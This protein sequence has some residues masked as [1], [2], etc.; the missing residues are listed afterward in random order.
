MLNGIRWLVVVLGL[1]LMMAAPLFGADKVTLKNGEVLEGEIVEQTDSYVVLRMDIG[2]IERRVIK[3][4]GEVAS[5][6]RESEGSEPGGDGEG[7]ESAGDD[8]EGS[9][10]GVRRPGS[11]EMAAA[12]PDGATR[13]AFIRLGNRLEGKDM[14][15]PY[16]NGNALMRSTE[17]LREMPEELRPEVVVLEIDSG[18]GAVAELEDIIEAIEEDL[19][20]DFRVVA[21][22]RFAISGAAFTAMNMEEI[23]FMSSGQMGGNVAFSQTGQGRAQSVQGEGLQQMLEYGRRVAR[24]GRIDPKVMWAM[25]RFMTLSADIDEAGRVTWY[26]GDQGEYIVSPGDKILTLNALQAVKFGIAEGIADNREEL[27][28]VLG[29]EEWVAVGEE[30]DEYQEDFRDAVWETQAR[31]NELLSKMEIAMELAADADSRTE[32]MRQIGRAKRFLGQLRSLVRRAPSL[33]KY[34][35]MTREWFR[36]LEERI[37]ELQDRYT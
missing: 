19:K 8:R 12:V 30:A 9:R 25:Q 27:M 1:V 32:F 29:I 21:W 26:E 6:E 28:D 13:V 31:A 11:R 17:I 34:Q 20:K 23:V 36:E 15:G 22:I 3:V 16:L 35:G 33:E 37:E 4:M 5:I 14:V 10:E 7:G 2:G 18:G 24:N